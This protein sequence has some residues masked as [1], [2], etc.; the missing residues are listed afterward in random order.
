MGGG[1]SGYLRGLTGEGAKV[2]LSSVVAGLWDQYADEDAPGYVGASVLT[3]RYLGPRFLG[4]SPELRRILE[5]QAG[6]ADVVHS[7]GLRML[8]S[9]EARRV[10]RRRGVPLVISPH[11]Q[12]DPWVLRR[13]PV[14]KRVLGWLYE[15]RNLRSAACIHVTADQEARYVREYGLTNPVAVVPI[16]VDAA[17]Y[18]VDA[19]GNGDEIVERWPELAGKKWLLYLS[20][21]YRKKGIHRLAAA[22]GRLHR[23]W[24]GWRLVVAGQDISHDRAEAE[25]IIAE[26][27][28]A[29]H[30]TFLGPVSEPVKKQLLAGAGVFV[31]PTDGENFG[32]AVAE[33]MASRV[34]VIVSN[35][36]PW[37]DLKKHGCGWWIDVGVEPLCAA[38]EQ[39]MELTDDQ[40]R[41]MGQRARRIIEE[42]YSWPV[43]AGQM[44]ELYR[45]VSGGGRRPSFVYAQGQAVP[46]Q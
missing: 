1:V 27:G 40:R 42:K 37:G 18:G 25:R 46:E 8:P 21:I 31:L 41:Q 26:A 33:A 38:L 16:G 39:A 44:R 4:Y 45:W 11:G 6:E 14:R 3:G 43:I 10:A 32:I 2:G 9:Y 5:E 23:R 17:A 7:H 22:W 13:N 35:T 24:P 34:P 19:A 30:T 28:A 20:T 36:T 12:L 15:G 29:A